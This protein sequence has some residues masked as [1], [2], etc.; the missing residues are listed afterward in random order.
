MTNKDILK[1]NIRKIVLNKLSKL[2]EDQIPV[3]QQIKPEPGTEATADTNQDQAVVDQLKGQMNAI[4]GGLNSE[5][6]KATKGEGEQVNESLLTI[7]SIAVALPAIMGLIA[8]FG[9][10]AG[11]MVNKVMGK[12]PTEASAYQAWLDK[13]AKIADDLHHL[14]MLPIQGV[15]SKF[16]KDPIKAKK[17]SSFI[18]HG[19]VAV[20]LL[21]SG[22]TAVKA[23]HSKEIS[24]AT[25]EA[26]L[27]A[28]KG[29]ELQVFISSALK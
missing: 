18:F 25:L 5:L 13:L 1:E 23:F 19:I 7:A 22:V 15:V 26:A 16:V 20:L 21:A 17:V 8:R 28:V 3:Q 9:K 14:Y 27:S 12:K 2:N 11:E 4:I 10:F 29:G 6:D 24:L